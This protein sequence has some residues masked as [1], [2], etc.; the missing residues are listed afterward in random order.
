M[1]R[2]ITNRLHVKSLHLATK[3]YNPRYLLQKYKTQP[4]LFEM[5]KSQNQRRFFCKS[6]EILP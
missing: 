4:F 2:F 6:L 3:W 1:K 5:Y